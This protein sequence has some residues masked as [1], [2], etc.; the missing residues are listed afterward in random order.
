MKKKSKILHIFMFFVKKN[1]N[2]YST[3]K[4]SDGQF[5][6]CQIYTVGQPKI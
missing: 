3:V 1:Y 5:L 2:S 4:T 6:G